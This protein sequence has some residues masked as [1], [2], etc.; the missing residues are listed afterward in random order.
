PGAGMEWKTA[1][2]NIPS[3]D[4]TTT[5]TS[6]S[7]TSSDSAGCPYG[8]ALDDVSVTAAA[9]DP[10]TPGSGQVTLF[11]G[12]NYTGNCPVYGVGSHPHVETDGNSAGIPNNTS[13]SI[14]VGPGAYAVLHGVP[15]FGGNCCNNGW[16]N[17][18]ASDPDLHD[19]VYRIPSTE[20]A[21][22]NAF[23]SV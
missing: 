9:V 11:T 21:A 20:D 13:E 19:A 2:I 4:T 15:D 8:I 23:I 16:V 6:L 10:C 22:V 17:V 18:G 3:G 5:S 12:T 14:L 1:T 7:F